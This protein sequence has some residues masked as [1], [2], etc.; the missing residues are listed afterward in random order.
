MKLTKEDQEALRQFKMFVPE[1]DGT[2]TDWFEN[3]LI[4]KSE[5]K[6][7]VAEEVLYKATYNELIMEWLRRYEGLEH[8]HVQPEQM[9][10]INA[11]LRRCFGKI[12]SPPPDQPLVVKEK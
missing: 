2:A 8:L 12:K 5:E 6:E 4:K 9:Y 1:D 11:I 3:L 7:K 10:T